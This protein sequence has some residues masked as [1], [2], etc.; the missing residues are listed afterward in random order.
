MTRPLAMLLFVVTGCESVA[1]SAGDEVAAEEPAPL[2]SA[3]A[4]VEHGPHP[5]LRSS[6]RCGECHVA[7]A[8]S[9]SSSAHA[10][11][12]KD[13]LYLAMR[14][15]AKDASCDSCHAPLA[16][17][18]EP[19]S[20]VAGEGVTCDA[21][22][23]AERVELDGD[24]GR[25]VLNTTDNV[26]RGPL[27]DARD[28]YF[29]RVACEPMF[30]RSE[31]CAA[32]HTLSRH[33]GATTIAVHGEY[34]EW[35]ASPL[36]PAGSD[37]SCQS[38]HMPSRDGEVAEGWEGRARHSAHGGA[39]STSSPLQ[40]ALTLQPAADGRIAVVANVTNADAGHALPTGLPG[41]RLRIAARVVDGSGAELD[42]WEHVYGTWLVDDAGNEAPFYSATRVAKD[43]RIAAEA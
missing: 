21:C 11:S 16:H 19:G 42:R 18:L 12:A 8:E 20:A 30:E 33:A 43:D 15:D 28:H 6:H 17:L 39:T 1:R 36:G 13:P 38:C 29:H 37:A 9:W 32:C 27:C 10:G 24:R 26:K 23:T 35:K 5:K 41:R 34:E 14:D 4:P 22:H 2:P 25:L 31:M 3:A 40:V 7:I